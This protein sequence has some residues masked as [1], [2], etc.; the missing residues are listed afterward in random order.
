MPATKVTFKDKQNYID[1][2]TIP[3]EQKIDALDMNEL[4]KVVNDNAGELDKKTSITL[5]NVVQENLT[6][7]SVRDTIMSSTKVQ[8]TNADGVV[9]VETSSDNIRYLK[10][11]GTDS[12]DGKTLIDLMAKLISNTSFFDVNPKPMLDELKGYVDIT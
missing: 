9:L 12:I 7:S 2:P 10:K 1:N 4:K 3:E 6:M 5:D 8:V 11:D